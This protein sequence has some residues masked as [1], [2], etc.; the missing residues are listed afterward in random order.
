MHFSRARLR[1]HRNGLGL[2]E[3]TLAERV[4]LTPERYADV[5]SGA[6]EPN[7]L[8]VADLA[9]ALGVPLFELHAIDATWEEDY[10]DA[11]LQH[12]GPMS[13][14]EVARVARTLAPHAERRAS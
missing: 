6:V 8:L 11:V 13:T 4:G 9:R 10:A 1:G 7:E 2:A 5:E 14:E 12:L 3:A